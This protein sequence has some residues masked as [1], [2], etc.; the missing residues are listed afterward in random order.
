MLNRTR[1]AVKNASG[2]KVRPRGASNAAERG[3]PTMFFDPAA[4]SVSPRGE[5]QSPRPGQRAEVNEHKCLVAEESLEKLS[6][7]LKSFQKYDKAMHS[8][9]GELKRAAQN[10]VSYGLW[11]KGTD[12]SMSKVGSCFA[13]AGQFAQIYANQQST[14]CDRLAK[15]FIG[16]LGKQCSE[17]AAEARAL[18]KRF[19]K[20]KADQRKQMSRNNLLE[21]SDMEA[22]VQQDEDE[23]LLHDIFVR[24]TKQTIQ[25]HCYLKA[26]DTFVNQCRESL[27]HFQERVD[28]QLTERDKEESAQVAES[29]QEDLITSAADR[30]IEQ[31][32]G[33]LHQTISKTLQVWDVPEDSNA[34][35]RLA[36]VIVREEDEYLR[37][38]STV[39][40]HYIKVWEKDEKVQV[41][42][43]D[44]ERPLLFS[45]LMTIKQQTTDVIQ[46]WILCVQSP[47]EYKL[48][49]VFASAEEWMVR[50][51]SRFCDDY[52]YT[53]RVIDNA[54][55]QS[56]YFA[57]FVNGDSHSLTSLM[58]LPI[59]R[60]H[61]YLYY[62]E[63][64][65]ELVPAGD[66]AHPQVVTSF[67]NVSSL[68][69]QALA[70][71]AQ[72]Q[73]LT[74]MADVMERITGADHSA[75]V[76]T[77]AFLFEG[78]L[79]A[80]SNL[81]DLSAGDG[82][83]VEALKEKALSERLSQSHIFLFSDCLV[84]TKAP[85]MAAY[86]MQRKGFRVVRTLSL[87]RAMLRDISEDIL[88]NA[89]QILVPKQ[90]HNDVYTFVAASGGSK[91]DWLEN[92]KHAFNSMRKT[93][94]FSIPLQELMERPSNRGRSIP[95][96]VQDCLDQLILRGLHS[97]G[98]F[99]LSGTFSAMDS[100]RNE[101][102]RGMEVNLSE[103][104]I[105][106]VAGLLKMWM[107]ELPEPLLSNALYKDFLATVD[108]SIPESK[109]IRKIR[110]LVDML[111]ECNKNVVQALTKFFH[112]ISQNHESTKMSVSNLAIVVAP[113][114]LDD[115]EG[116]LDLNDQQL[117][118][119]VAGRMIEFY[120]KVFGHI[121]DSRRKKAELRMSMRL[122]RQ[123]QFESI[124]LD[125][126]LKGWK[127]AGER[128][129]EM[130]SK[131]SPAQSRQRNS[132]MGLGPSRSRSSLPLT[133]AGS[134]SSCQGGDSEA[135][136]KD[137]KGTTTTT[138]PRAGV[139][140]RVDSTSTK[141]GTVKRKSTRRLMAPQ[142]DLPAT[143]TRRY[144]PGT[145]S[146]RKGAPGSPP[147]G[148]VGAVAESGEPDAPPGQDG[149]GGKAEAGSETRSDDEIPLGR[150]P[151]AR[152]TAGENATGEDA[153]G[154]GSAA[155]P[156][157]GH[158]GLPVGRPQASAEGVPSS[159]GVSS[160]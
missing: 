137:R 16:P 127:E 54:K 136:G 4:P 144:A 138:S 61:R 70:A 135:A 109:S 97:V 32:E 123:K 28:E 110:K 29:V 20:V 107:R 103:A 154:S 14:C 102:D 49:E 31:A 92:L 147:G 7:V 113:N 85:V 105:H 151:L 5:E 122:E 80:S 159:Q 156:S 131:M 60:V 36:C 1:K 10:L 23:D 118:V 130:D 119:A 140:P 111:P 47:E 48:S 37:G 88:Q 69:T 25:V 93:K 58:N 56:R 2:R 67:M 68:V 57:N 128:I 117:S 3:P 98:I 121:E 78:P 11:L 95:I 59:R 99:R 45:N 26:F 96:I 63:T 19:E 116:K 44:Q 77:E 104:D 75:F 40:N 155:P 132:G 34:M 66:P 41:R 62:L 125:D 18:R 91:V 6:Q 53:L 15:T 112:M 39:E 149:D 114:L 94:V 157:T 100:L 148:G 134:P 65:N 86:N 27:T 84:E 71:E 145:T 142:K 42:I 8:A 46:D 22:S 129:Q 64:L 158:D 115:P 160:T 101:Y 106:D 120:G 141:Y 153:G 108:E 126:A 74:Q 35:R 52:P 33:K 51:Y 83:K 76:R 89:F 143:P 150:P 133:Q 50:E 139:S 79:Q 43:L 72:L 38:L 90:N 73:N 55:K 82:G 87:E 152:E 24:Q 21:E 81:T 124:E 30:K 146:P 9:V 13:S 17:D 12:E